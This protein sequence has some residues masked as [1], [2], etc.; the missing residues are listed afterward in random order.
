MGKFYSTSFV[1]C[2]SML[3]AFQAKAQYSGVAYQGV[4]PQVGVTL[5]VP[6]Q[7][8]LENY[9][10][11]SSDPNGD[12]ANFSD[13][14][15]DIPAG[16]MGTYND[17]SAGGVAGGNSVRTN[18]DV[19][20]EAG[21]SGNV[22]TAVQGQE[23]TIYTINVVTA[24]TYS[25][26]VNYRH[27]GNSKDVKI[28]SHKT[29]GTG[30]TLLYDSVPDGGLPQGDYITTDGLGS[31]ILPA[32]PLLIRFRSLDAGPRFDFFTLTLEAAMPLDLLDFAAQDNGKHNLLRW[33][34]ANEENVSHFTVERS[35]DGQDWNDLAEIAS[36]Q[37]LTTTDYVFQDETPTSTAYYRLRMV[38]ADGSFSYSP[39]QT[40]NREEA[41][42]VDIFPNPT[43][44]SFT[45]RYSGSDTEQAP[46][47]V[48]DAVGRSVR[49]GTLVS[50][51]ANEIQLG[52]GW[53]TVVVQQAGEMKVQRVIVR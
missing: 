35:T 7:I 4:V 31:F 11:L 1:F 52:S 10:A 49:S 39:L 9:D 47:T 26:G 30:K 24:G 15:D 38:D 8:E 36:A 32:G 23:Y 28:F 21:G 41:S 3:F 17:K 20:I 48:Y 43:S 46:F 33:T 34:T 19:D 45:L 44:G 5:G 22:T 40:V 27:F 13:N 12:G 18:S 2:L 25:F 42:K 37:Q 16:V 6:V 14:T 50:D 53:Y 29:D 51:T